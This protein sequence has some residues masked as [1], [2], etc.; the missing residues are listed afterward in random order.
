MKADPSLIVQ[1]RALETQLRALQARVA[2]QSNGE[3]DSVPT[4]RSFADLYGIL[5]NEP[6][7][8]LDEI[9]AAEISWDWEEEEQKDDLHS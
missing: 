5:R 8:T 9:R 4:I 7:F 2:A 6:S 3:D 1:I